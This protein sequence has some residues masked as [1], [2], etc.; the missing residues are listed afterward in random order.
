MIDLLSHLTIACNLFKFKSKKWYKK[1]KKK[2]GIF[3]L[4]YTLKFH[5]DMA[6]IIVEYFIFIKYE[7]RIFYKFIVWSVSGNILVLTKAFFAVVKTF[8]WESL[9]TTTIEAIDKNISRYTNI[10]KV[11]CMMCRKLPLICKYVNKN[12]QFLLVL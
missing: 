5:V 4:A 7:N 1:K 10:Y 12:Q 8:P 11:S 6:T 2:K 9:L 3:M